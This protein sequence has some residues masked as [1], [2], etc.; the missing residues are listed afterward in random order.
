MKKNIIIVGSL[1]VLTLGQ[2]ALA[3]DD[4]RRQH[5]HHFHGPLHG[6]KNGMVGHQH[7]AGEEA[8]Q[9]H[10]PM[11]AMKGAFV[12]SKEVDGFTVNFHIMK[13]MDGM[14]AMEGM[15]HGGSN[16]L[17]IKVVRG[18]KVQTDLVVNSKVTHPNG[19]SE[20]KMM[21][22]MG[23]WYM[24]GYDLDH[25]GQHQVMVLFKTPDGNTHFT[26]IYYPQHKTEGVQNRRGQD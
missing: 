5:G 25:A 15:K 14:K 24:A 17:M 19:A 13:A 1:L 4:V 2:A 3:H 11:M 16:S 22:Q 21:M 6:D 10:E 20:S 8:M 7:Q 26:G 18:G 23:D 12:S 9:H